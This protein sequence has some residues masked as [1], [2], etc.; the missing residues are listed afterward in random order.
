MIKIIESNVLLD[1]KYEA[2]ILIKAELSKLAHG[3]VDIN[4]YKR[5]KNEQNRK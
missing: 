2:K 3:M 1:N 5:D 4:Y